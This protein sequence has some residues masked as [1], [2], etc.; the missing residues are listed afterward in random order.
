MKKSSI[1][2]LGTTSLN[3]Q[4]TARQLRSYRCQLD[5]TFIANLSVHQATVNKLWVDSLKKQCLQSIADHQS[6]RFHELNEQSKYTQASIKVVDFIASFLE[7]YTHEFNHSVGWNLHISC[8]KPDFIHERQPLGHALSATYQARASTRTWSLVIRG[9]HSTVSCYLVP[10]SQVLAIPIL[11]NDIQPIA[12]LVALANGNPPA[13]QIQWYLGKTQ[14]SETAMFRMCELIFEEFLLRHAS[15]QEPANGQIAFLAPEELEEKIKM[16][17]DVSSDARQERSPE[18]AGVKKEPL[19]ADSPYE[20]DNVIHFNLDVPDPEAVGTRFVGTPEAMAETL[21]DLDQLTGEGTTS[22][23]A[24]QAGQAA[25][26]IISRLASIASGGKQ[27]TAAT[28]T[29]KSKRAKTT[30]GKSATPETIS[31]CCQ[32]IMS[33]TQTLVQLIDT[34]VIDLTDSGAQ[35]FLDRKMEE[36]K[37]I[38]RMVLDRQSDLSQALTLKTRWQSLVSERWGTAI[39]SETQE[40]TDH[41][42]SVGTDQTI[43]E[44]IAHTLDKLLCLLSEAGSCALEKLDLEVS[45]EALN[46]MTAVADFK[47]Q[48]ALLFSPAEIDMSPASDK[49]AS[50]SDDRQGARGM[51][52]DAPRH[53]LPSVG[54]D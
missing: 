30:A 24:S 25:Q 1:S 18:A 54:A 36:V 11:A 41:K 45:R 19:L 5:G 47:R 28:E 44:E 22:A 14:L 8:T 49:K 13:D 29:P 42:E 38:Y 37:L 16:S 46:A 17:P 43:V 21:E 23:N 26:Q 15:L 3:R 31:L 35:A 51:A 9:Q 6:Q 34:E 27:P 52:Q 32:R 12:Q 33:S 50:Q 39:L 7:G 20:E 53:T 40:R 10:A 4:E 2:S 48:L